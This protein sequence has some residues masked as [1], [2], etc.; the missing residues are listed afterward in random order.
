MRK[1]IRIFVSSEAVAAEDTAVI[2]TIS[3]NAKVKPLSGLV[4][5]LGPEEVG[6][7]APYETSMVLDVGGAMGESLIWRLRLH[8]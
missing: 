7:D 2:N 1:N 5:S 8:L 6:D 3:E 4:I